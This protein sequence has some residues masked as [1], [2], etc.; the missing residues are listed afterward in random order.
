M[1]ENH[2][3]PMNYWIILR[4]CSFYELSTT[5][6]VGRCCSSTTRAALTLFSQSAPSSMR[7][8]VRVFVFVFC[9]HSPNKTFLFTNQRSL[10]EVKKGREKITLHQIKIAPFD[11]ISKLL[12][13]CNE[14]P[15]FLQY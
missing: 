14:V 7:S 9:I 4:R 13:T 15:F 1:M 8:M 12:S 5:L 10:Y 2:A 6:I 11:D 3:L